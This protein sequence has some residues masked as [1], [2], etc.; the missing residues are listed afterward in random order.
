VKAGTVQAEQQ[1]LTAQGLAT[2][3]SLLSAASTLLEESPRI[4]VGAV[5]A[6][7]GVSTGLL[8]RYFG[9]KDGLVAAVVDEFYDRYDNAVF[10]AP[11]DIE[12][13][14]AVREHHRIA[15]QVDFAYDDPLGPALIGNRIQEPAAIATD[16]TRWYQHIDMAARNVEW[17]QRHGELDERVDA[18]LVAAAILGA[19]RSLVG[20][21][22]GRDEPPPRRT[23]VDTAWR[24]GVATLIVDGSST[25]GLGPIDG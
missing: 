25:R 18:R 17:A 7:A 5:A 15:L 4:E 8:Y 21:A 6:I 19:F 3:A 10:L 14:W 20:E 16:V 9:S 13:S 24:L 1:Q 22:L 23:I 11:L 2:R 12:G